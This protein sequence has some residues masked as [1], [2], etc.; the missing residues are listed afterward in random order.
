MSFATSVQRSRGAILGDGGRGF[1][2]LPAAVQAARE[3]RAR[4]SEHRAQP[5]SVLFFAGPEGPGI[6]AP[7]V[8][9]ASMTPWALRQVGT[10]AGV[11]AQVVDR[12]KP[13]TAAQVLNECLDRGGEPVSLL[14]EERNGGLLRAVTS[15]R[16]RRVWDADLWGEVAEWLAPHGW[17]PAYP[18]RGVGGEAVE[19]RERAI[20]R[21][22]R[23]S[24]AFF[25]ST[26]DP[27]RPIPPTVGGTGWDDDGLG[28]MRR[29]LVVG[30]SEVGARSLTW[31][32]GWYRGLCCNFLVWGAEE[33][34]TRRRRHTAGVLRELRDLRRWVREQSGEV[35]DRDLAPFRA[36]AAAQAP[37]PQSTRK[38]KAA[39]WDER[40]AD[41]LVGTFGAP[42]AAAREAAHF[43]AR[44]DE[45]CKPG[46]WWALV[47]GLTGPA[48][49]KVT[50]GD[51]FD[52][53]AGPAAALVSAGVEALGAL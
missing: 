37:V 39:R 51:L 13:A 52:L 17:E 23:D 53:V 38:G 8:S 46:T 41:W 27:S 14:R 3:Q 32:S 36:L 50:P 33:V 20:W 6:E 29:L 22:D 18:E 21:S 43:A 40:A 45:A 5:R 47:Q 4:C 1:P 2:G 30:N 7:G 48:A 49:R 28:G 24:F 25:M 42:V 12:L 15:T 34:T 44:G 19:N 31:S 10:L 9:C 35:S 11:P 16:Y 26:R